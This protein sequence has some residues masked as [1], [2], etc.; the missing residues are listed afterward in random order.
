V[1]SR[2]GSSS[3]SLGLLW[4]PFSPIETVIPHG[5]LDVGEGDVEGRLLLLLI[6]HYRLQGRELVGKELQWPN[7]LLNGG[8]AGDDILEGSL[9]VRTRAGGRGLAHGGSA[10]LAN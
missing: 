3:S 8:E 5:A 10:T 6:G 7:D 1:D 9:L 4:W 2:S